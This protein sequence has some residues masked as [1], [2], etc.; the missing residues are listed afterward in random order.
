MKEKRVKIST[1][2]DNQFPSFIK[3]E[4]PLIVDFFKSYYNSIEYFGGAA[5]ILTNI[6]NYT[7]VEVLVSDTS[8]MKLQGSITSTDTV[9]KTINVNVAKQLPDTYGLLK[10]DDE[11]ITYTNKVTT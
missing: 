4:Y 5:D 11:I 10:I 6:D 2:L 9:I 7:N 1:I 8:G 3:D